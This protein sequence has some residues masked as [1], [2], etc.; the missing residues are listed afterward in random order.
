M[1]FPYLLLNLKGNLKHSLLT[2]LA[3]LLPFFI[4]FPWI[5]DLLLPTAKSLLTQRPPTEY[6]QLPQLIKTYGYLPILFCLMGTFWLAIK[7]GKKNYSLILGLLALLLMLVTFYTFHYGVAIVYERGLMYM[8]LMLSIVA[9]A[10]LSAVKNLS[11]PSRIRLWRGIRP[12]TPYLGRVLCIIF[13][14]IILVVIVPIRL[15]AKYYHTINED[16]YQA[17]VWIRENIGAD[18]QTAILDPWKATAFTAITSKYIYSRIHASP[19]PRDLEAY[20]FLHD[21]CRD[22]AF[23]RENRISIV[24]SQGSCSNPD[25]V[26]VRP[27]VY[28]LPKS[29]D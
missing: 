26:E 3:L 23:L 28:L 24:Y 16:D 13:I 17:F 29:G 14:G 7:G 4:I 11:L 10:G 27:G 21:G 18:Y 22:T 15:D 20:Q 2:A 5:S 6:V 25:L 19:Q 9:G 1:L 8:M 12:I